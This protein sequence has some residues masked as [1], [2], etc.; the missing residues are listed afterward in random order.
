MKVI[1]ASAS[2]R[3]KELLS[4]IFPLFHVIPSNAEEN[5]NEILPAKQHVAYLAKVKAQ[6][7]FASH[8]SALVLG[9]DTIVVC[10]ERILEKPKNKVEAREMM[11]FLSGRSHW[12]YTAVHLCYQQ[13]QTT[14]VE[15]TE[16]TFSQM[17]KEEKESYISTDE[18]YDK[19]GGYGVQGLASKYITMLKGDYFNVCGL[20]ISRLYRELKEFLGNNFLDI[21]LD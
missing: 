15:E 12:V 1:L 4:T 14:F 3:R 17:S 13:K 19:A 2:P 8:P 16:V 11:D 7:I 18:P 9:S 6:D 10:G 20:P 5:S 21:P